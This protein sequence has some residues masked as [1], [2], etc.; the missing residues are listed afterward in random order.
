MPAAPESRM[1]AA[2]LLFEDAPVNAEAASE[3]AAE[4]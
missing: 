3:P 1:P 2:P 4:N